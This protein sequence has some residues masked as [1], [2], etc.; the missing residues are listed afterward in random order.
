[1][2]TEISKKEKPNGI[3]ENKRVAKRGGSVAG[4]ARLDTEKELGQSIVSEE[5]YL[6]LGKSAKKLNEKKDDRTDAEVEEK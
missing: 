6:P 2:T 3:P 4:K 1:M 5:N